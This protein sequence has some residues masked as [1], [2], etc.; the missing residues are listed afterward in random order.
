[1]RYISDRNNLKLVMMLLRDKRANIQFEAFH[2]FKVF[3][4]NPQKPAP[5]TAILVQ[6]K[7]KLID[8]LRKF[9]NDKED[10]QFTEEKALLIQTLQ[11]MKMPM[12]EEAKLKKRAA[13][14]EASA[15]D[16][17]GAG[18]ASGGASAESSTAAAPA[19]EGVGGASGGAGGEAG[20]ADAG[21][22]SEATPKAD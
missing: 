12:E 3:V 22:A 4:A 13:A 10:D 2:V 18:D 1:M 15:G 6:N 11:N 21:K 7:E 8:Y 20:T 19:A 14:K 5:I 9:H 16:A 17:A